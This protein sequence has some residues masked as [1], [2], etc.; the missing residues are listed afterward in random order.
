VD[1]NE[2]YIVV[3]YYEV[4]SLMKSQAEN[5]EI[6]LE[7]LGFSGFEPDDLMGL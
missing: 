7:D 6:P 5:F 2:R 1:S 4:A 3:A